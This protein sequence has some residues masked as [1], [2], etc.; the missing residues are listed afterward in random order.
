LRTLH[1]TVDSLQSKSIGAHFVL[2]QKSGKKFILLEFLS[3][4]QNKNSSRTKIDPAHNSRDGKK[5]QAS[6]I[7][8]I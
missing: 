8:H 4:E 5:L 1:F 2:E 3:S 6:S 7:K